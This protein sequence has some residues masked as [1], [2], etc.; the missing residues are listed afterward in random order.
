MRVHTLVIHH[1]AGPRSQ[2]PAAIKRFHTEPKPQGR[3]WSDVGYHA[4]IDQRGKIHH[5]RN[6]ADIGAHAPPNTGRLGV[7]VIGDN[8][9]PDQKWNALQWDALRTYVRACQVVFPGLK[10]VAH[11]DTKATAC[12]GLSMAEIRR[13]IA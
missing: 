9:D 11:R 1:S 10:V 4:L 5:G 6:P 3:G 13:G 2:T 7:C 12:P 8:T